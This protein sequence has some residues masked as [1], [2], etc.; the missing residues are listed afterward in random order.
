MI[1]DKYINLDME[2]NLLRKLGDKLI[3]DGFHSGNTIIITVSTDYSSIAGQ[4]LRHALSHNEEVCDGFGVD[5]PYPDESFNQKYKQDVYN[6]FNMHMDSV[7]NKSI[8][9]VEA[10]VIRGSNYTT[11]VD[12]IKNDLHIN[13]P[14][15]TLAMYENINSVFKSDYVGDYYNNEIEDLTF[16]WE[17]ANKHWKR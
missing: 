3:V 11:I 14:I 16:W 13:E 1:I 12:L 6:M 15:I 10:G 7:K 2:V 4:Y 9:L 17:K 8:L 5:V